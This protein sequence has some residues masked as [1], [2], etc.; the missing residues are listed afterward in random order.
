VLSHSE[1]PTLPKYE[2]VDLFSKI[3]ASVGLVF[4]L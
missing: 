4:Y 3:M 2:I 1:F